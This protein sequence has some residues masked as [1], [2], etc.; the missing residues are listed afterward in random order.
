MFHINQS[1]SPLRELVFLLSVVMKGSGYPTHT[2]ITDLLLSHTQPYFSSFTLHSSF[3]SVF[4]SFF[5]S[6]R[7]IHLIP[8]PHP[9]LLPT[10]FSFTNPTCRARPVVNLETELRFVTP[11]PGKIDLGSADC[12][13]EKGE[14]VIWDG[15][16]R[17][18]RRRRMR[19]RRR[20]RRRRR[21]RRV[22]MMICFR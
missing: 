1:A 13:T 9:P 21:K 17:R 22:M 12:V 16:S 19:K 20:G 15:G 14:Q 10:P 11:V 4:H 7:F 3:I 2:C 18:G 6:P 5:S 8:R